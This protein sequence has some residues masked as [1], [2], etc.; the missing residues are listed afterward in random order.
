M[1]LN[2]I[3]FTVVFMHYICGNYTDANLHQD[4]NFYTIVFL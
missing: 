3:I 4:N 1:M 2:N